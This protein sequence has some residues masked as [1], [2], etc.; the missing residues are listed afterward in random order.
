MFQTLKSKLT[1]AFFVAIV[2]SI[3]SVSIVVF[4]GI[5]KYSRSSFETTSVTN[6]QLIDAYITEL[7]T[8][9]MNNIKYLAN[10]E[11]SRQSP[12]HLNKFFGPEAI[13]ANAKNEDP[14]KRQLF[15]TFENMV[16]NHPKYEAVYLASN[17]GELLI[18]PSLN[19]PDGFDPRKRPWYQKMLASSQT[20]ELSKAYMSTSGSPVITITARVKDQ[21]STTAGVI[22]MDINLE[23]LTSLTSR[24]KL[25]R[26][27]YIMLLE[28]DGTILSDPRH[29]KLNFK[30]AQDTTEPALQKL[31]KISKGTFKSQIDNEDK[32]ITV[33]TSEST[34]WKLAYIIDTAEVFESSNTMLITALLIGSGFGVVLLVGAWLLAKNLLRPLNLMASSAESIAKGNFNALPDPKYFSGEFLMLYA[35]IKKMVEELVKSISIS[36]NKTRDVEE[37]SQQAQEALHEAKE[38]KTQAEKAQ[39]DMMQAAK[40]LE[41]IVEQVTAASQQLSVQITN[42]SQGATTQ[43][44]RTTKVVT[45][46]EEMNSSVIEVARNSSRAAQNAEDARKEAENGEKIVKNVV[47]SIEQVNAKAEDMSS[48]LD[49]LGKQAEDIGQIMTVITDIAD[50]TNLLALNAAIEAARAGEAGRGF[51]VVADEVRKLAEKTMAATKEVGNSVDAIQHGAGGAI[52]DMS[53]TAQLVNQ[54]TEFAQKAG[55]ALHSILDIVDTTAD[56]VRAIAAASEEQSSASEEI[57]HSTEEVNEIAAKTNESMQQSTLAVHDLTQLTQEMVSLIEQLKQE[58]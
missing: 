6:L 33:L 16:I 7:I 20:T 47:T 29:K 26:T 2:L 15:K 36:E 49:S 9:G 8:E 52:S 54:S 55:Q 51:A 31:T 41:E 38:A 40:T 48:R 22:G 12:G 50:Q 5:N 43:H 53:E 14:Q 42:A 24:L 1:V 11:S 58:E 27:G 19:L 3:T 17:L 30:K 28:H 45:A 56:Q 18:Y 10:L 32:F 21:S 46:I 25:G 39:S 23:T 4:V 35:S 34:G 57:N 13:R 37:Q 44:D